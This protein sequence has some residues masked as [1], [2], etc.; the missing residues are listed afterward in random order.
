[1]KTLRSILLLFLCFLSFSLQA[2]KRKDV[3]KEKD[4]VQSE[5]QYPTQF[6]HLTDS[7]KLLLQECGMAHWGKRDILS[8]KE[9]SRLSD[10]YLKMMED[11]GFP[12]A[13]TS[14]VNTQLNDSTLYADLL[15]E[16]NQ[17]ILFDSIILKGDLRLA[18]MFLYP[19]LGVRHNKPYCES[20]MQQIPSR[21]EE[22]AYA[23][24]E[25]PSDV[26]FMEDKSYLYLFLN[27]KQVNQFDGVL[28]IVPVSEKSGKVA[29]T[30]QL[31]LSLKNLFTI[32]ESIELHWLAP[33][34]KSQKL[35]LNL[36]F[37]YLFR[38]PLG[39]SFDFRLDKT[40]TTYLNMNYVV[41]IQYSFMGNS[42]IK[43]YFDYTTSNI[44]HG[45]LVI[46]NENLFQQ[47]DF[48]KRLY[49]LSA[50]IRKLDY[51]YNPRKGFSIDVDAA[52]GKRNIRQNATAD[53][54]IY[55]ESNLTDL[56]YRIVGEIRGYIPIRKHWVIFLKGE[57]G[58]LYS[59]Y[60]TVYN[61]LF[62]IGGLNSLR[63]V[64]ENGITASSYVIAMAELRFIFA[65]RS[66]INVFYNHA[67]YERN[68]KGEYISDAP[69]GFG[70][71]IALDTRA[72][73]F[74]LNYALGKEY[75]NPISFKTGKIHF[76]LA[77][78]F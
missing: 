58:S 47:A 70:L 3:I 10:R 4:K 24:E 48:K 67:W 9:Y 11:H 37:P 78:N 16:K 76:G 36:L 6:I 23:T 55:G 49:G 17:Y 19:Y 5:Q 2:Q 44:L 77:V 62:K 13:A 68:I 66:Y 42:Y 15:L 21:I 46:Q 12:F 25:R 61:D 18:K 53:P 39:I 73:I 20:T 65:K 1:M 56:Q 29:I 28:G 31:D 59:R 45:D 75:N 60:Q 38:T 74:S 64:N 57:G 54:T 41:G 33:E 26:E 72:G 35:D 8:Y 43:A 7:A 52:V 63:G 30:G 69:F 71:G 34:A 22:L 27:K 14:L 40:D 32:G 50:H 51:L